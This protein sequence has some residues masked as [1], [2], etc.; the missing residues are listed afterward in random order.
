ML[1]LNLGKTQD[2]YNFTNHNLKESAMIT[3]YNVVTVI[4]PNPIQSTDAFNPC[5]T[6]VQLTGL[7]VMSK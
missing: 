4:P 2:S 3:N 6:L 1:T 7:R 5:P